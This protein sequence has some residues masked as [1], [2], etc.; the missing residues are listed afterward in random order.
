MFGFFGNFRKKS[1]K[2][3]YFFS[4]TNPKEYTVFSVKLEELFSVEMVFVFGC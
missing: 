4:T 2:T 3:E 1:N